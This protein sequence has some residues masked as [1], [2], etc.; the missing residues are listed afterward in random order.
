MLSTSDLN[1]SFEKKVAE[2]FPVMLSFGDSISDAETVSTYTIRV[3][4]AEGNESASAVLAQSDLV[5]SDVIL[6]VI[7]G[8]ADQSYL[9]TVTVTTDATPPSVYQSDVAMHVK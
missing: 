2:A 9:F 4:D 3:E 1:G 7:G 5:G 6:H 8:E